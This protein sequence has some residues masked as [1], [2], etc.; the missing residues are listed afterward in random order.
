[1]G[2]GFSGDERE[3]NYTC[4][5][6]GRNN[7]HKCGK[8]GHFKK[9]YQGLNTSY[10]QR[11]VAIT[12]EDGNTL[13]YE[14]TVANEGR[15]RFTDVWLFDTGPTFHMTARI[16]WFHQY[17][18]ISEG[19]SV[20]SCNDHELK[21]IRIRS[22]M[23]KMHD[24]EKVFANLYQLKGEIMQE[25]EASVTSHSPSHKAIV[26]WHQ[27]LRHMFEQGM[28]ILMERKLLPWVTK[29]MLVYPIKES[30]DV[31]KSLKFTK[32]ARRNQKA[33]HNGIHSSTKWSGK[34]DKQNLVRKSKSNV[35]NYKLGKSFW[36]E[37]VNIAKQEEIE[38]LHKNKMWEFMPQPGRRKPIGNKWVY[39][40][41]RNDDDQVEQYRAR[42]VVKGYA[43]KERI[44][45]TEIFSLVVRM[46]I[47]RVVLAMC[48]TYDLH[49]HSSKEEMMEMS[50]I[51]YV[52]AV[53]SLM[54]VMICTRLD[55]A[56]EM[57]IVSRE[58]DLIVK[59]YVYSDYA[60]D[61]DGSKST[62]R[63][64]FTLFG[65]TVSSASKL[66]TVVAMS[67]TKVKYIAAAQVSKEAV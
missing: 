49:S 33:V 53:G 43:Q 23:V 61:L 11:D 50:R 65:R 40:N 63:Y 37:A 21:I 19:G 36:A 52:S 44:D 58:L 51:P 35:G 47:I 28:K 60:C 64:V 4:F 15:K 41:K 54:F 31:F 66:Q 10:P 26:T 56:H 42:L 32:R 25:A 17:K 2:G 20:Y 34:V 1:M 8:P 38:A 59:G 57:G 14:A 24:G 3:V 67:T 46:T 39:K 5:K 45:F 12:K 62:T 30:F 55:I 7:G 27:K 6:S 13:C 9:Y 22:T 29:E 48:A 18:S 16:E